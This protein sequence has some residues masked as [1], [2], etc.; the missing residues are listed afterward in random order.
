MVELL[1][2]AA[3]DYFKEDQIKE[4]C[5]SFGLITERGKY[6]AGISLGLMHPLFLQEIIRFLKADNDRS[7][8][9]NKVKMAD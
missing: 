7:K 6:K 4:L 1:E 8:E 3:F 9:P 2:D 5:D